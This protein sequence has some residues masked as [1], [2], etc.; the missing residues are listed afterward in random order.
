MDSKQNGIALKIITAVT[1]AAMIAVNAMANALPINGINTGAVSDAY[2]NLFAPAGLTFAIWGLIYLLLAG[3]TLYQF[4]LFQGDKSTVKTELLRKVNIVFSISSLANFCWIFSWHYRIIPLS[5]LL[6]LVILACLIY[7]NGIIKKEQLSNKE[8]LFIKLPFSIYFGWIT[9]ATIANMTT[10]LVAV[11]WNGFGISEPIWTV[12][13]LITGL[14]IGSVTMILNRDVA[15]GFVLVWA[16]AGILLKHMSQAGFGGQY[17]SVITTV[18][19][20]I[21]LFGVALGYVLFAKKPTAGT[22]K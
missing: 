8:K 5:M 6:M 21:V 2:P 18:I 1:Y 14:L 12:A 17:P 3:Y 16:Y 9:V 10:L 13:I 22:V 20:C 4:G 11:G 7:I 19:A 15:Y